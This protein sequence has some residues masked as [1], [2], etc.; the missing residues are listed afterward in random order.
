MFAALLTYPDA[1][2]ASTIELCPDRS[3][4]LS[5]FASATATVSPDEM[6]E[7][8]TRTFD[9]NPISSLEIG[10]HLYGEAYE[11]GAFLVKMRDLLRRHNVPESTELPDHLVHALEVLSKMEEEEANPFI[12]AC[13]LPAVRKMLDGFSKQSTPYEHVLRALLAVI[14]ERQPQ[15][16]E[17]V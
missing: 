17:H 8:Y 1:E 2:H 4:H 15:G 11:R 16:V 5:A 12:T 13:V 6:E 9:I 10:W 14:G 7:L 3:G